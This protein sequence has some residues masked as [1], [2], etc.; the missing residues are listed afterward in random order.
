MAYKKAVGKTINNIIDEGGDEAEILSY[1]ND[2]GENPG[3]YL[4]TPEPEKQKT[5]KLFE[6][7]FS[8]PHRK[9]LLPGDTQPEPTNAG[10][11]GPLSRVMEGVSQ[12]KKKDIDY[13]LKIA[14]M[15]VN[16]SGGI[17]KQ[18]IASGLASGAGK[19]GEEL[20]QGEDVKGAANKALDTAG[21]AASIT[22]ALGVGGKA[23]GA[24]GSAVSP[25]IKKAGSAMSGIPLDKYSEAIK[26][27]FEVNPVFK[28]GW[29]NAGDQLNEAADKVSSII[30]RKGDYVAG[31]ESQFIDKNNKIKESYEAKV[32][33]IK[34]SNKA[35][36]QKNKEIQEAFDKLQSQSFYNAGE[37]ALS[38]IKG[39]E[40]KAGKVVGKAREGLIQGA[41]KSVLFADDLVND[42]DGVI[43]GATI[44]DPS[45]KTSFLAPSE[46]SFLKSIKKELS[47]GKEV[48]KSLS[49]SKGPFGEDVLSMQETINQLPISEARISTIINKIDDFVTYGPKYSSDVKTTEGEFALKKVRNILNEKLRGLSPELADANDIFSAVKDVK[50]NLASRTD[51][52]LASLIEKYHLGEVN[53]REKAAIEKLEELSGGRFLSKSKLTPP[54][55]SQDIPIPI[56]PKLSK[57]LPSDIQGNKDLLSQLSGF[58][59]ERGAR[60]TF[61]NF[62]K[63]TPEELSAL[64]RVSNEIPDI[65]T[66]AKT[67]DIAKEFL[68]IRPTM[69]G[70]GLGLGAGYG[71][72][73]FSPS[74]AVALAMSTAAGTSPRVH[75]GVIRSLPFAAKGVGGI[76]NLMKRVV[77]TQVARNVDGS[78]TS[79]IYDQ[80]QAA[81]RKK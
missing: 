11:I 25:Y 78:V 48:T 34:N 36:K 60:E 14:P 21:T 32:I 15:L 70:T 23:L 47:G 57:K 59:K 52:S 28:K 42:V 74:L 3:D 79:N 62:E 64:S 75:S 20:L 46:M 7:L 43:A 44:T 31:A 26:R 2:I 5:P 41:S 12:D 73:R 8:L 67:A 17:M 35:A 27:Q 13:L 50:S 40:S 4:S 6:S 77:P 33:E 55:F 45:G 76:S 19:F 56:K 29:K 61:Q 10:K 71:V 22:G 65:L 53:S 63:I 51:K 66:G 37:E 24:V 49:P 1:L 69:G 38:A 16:P 39:L 18:A 72:S 30:K 9:S 54:S 58:T 80:Y 68:R 81:R